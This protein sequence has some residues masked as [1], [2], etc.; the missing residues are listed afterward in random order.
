[1]DRNKLYTANLYVITTIVVIFVIINIM[2]G[3]YLGAL[4]NFLCGLFLF[5]LGSLFR[6]S[7][8]EFFRL[9]LLSCGQYLIIFFVAL[10]K[11]TMI[12]NVGLMIAAC[13]ITCMYFDKRLVV[14]Q[15]IVVNVTLFFAI[16]FLRESFGGVG[17]DVLVRPLL[18][19]EI[20]LTFAYLVTNWGNEFIVK[21]HNK[22]VQTEELLK[23]IQEKMAESEQLRAEQE[24]FL[25]EMSA[26]AEEKEKLLS[27]VQQKMKESDEAVALQH[28]AMQQVNESMKQNE[29]LLATVNEKMKESEHLSAE[30]EKI[31]DN[32]RAVAKTVTSLSTQMKDVSQ[33]LTD[34]T[35]SQSDALQQLDEVVHKMSKEIQ[36]V[37]KATKTSGEYASKAE[38]MIQDAN[39]KM[40]LLLQA[41]DSISQVSSEIG[42]II[43]TIESISFQT[44]LLA[45]NASVEA[46]HA[47]HMGKGFAVVADEVR[48][49]ASKSSV[50]AKDTAARIENILSAVN[51]ARKIA[52]ET[53]NKLEETVSATEDSD[54][55]VRSIIEITDSQL[56]LVKT[57]ENAMTTI[58][59][60]ISQNLQTVTTNTDIA[61]RLLEQSQL[62]LQ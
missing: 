53:A 31:L 62:M 50:A 27:Q 56:D 44:N 41:M 55:S 8:S 43:K 18:S 5:V 3:F 26:A 6:R 12:D 49:L 20:T 21:A 42:T 40:N 45:I 16:V 35:R 17:L 2:E 51:Q 24:R 54:K 52:A 22:A 33:L 4:V 13:V 46:A 30:Q 29:Q 32:I 48:N 10:F 14:I 37:T 36:H 11:R 58:S 34:G 25:R 7:L 59:G 9:N 1:M 39:S 38:I 47:G 57:L 28:K 23:T 15:G 61:A 19:I 60:S